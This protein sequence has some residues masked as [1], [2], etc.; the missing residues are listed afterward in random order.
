MFPRPVRGNHVWSDF[1][2]HVSRSR[3]ARDS[4]TQWHSQQEETSHCD[5]PG[6][7]ETA[8]AFSDTA[9]VQCCCN[10]DERIIWFL[11][12]FIV[13]LEFSLD[14]ENVKYLPGIKLG[15]NSLLLLYRPWLREQKQS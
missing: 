8:S 5:I 9:S 13:S 7:S 4:P 10:R 3:G 11:I 6:C 12:N 14:Q 15:R 1:G 2:A